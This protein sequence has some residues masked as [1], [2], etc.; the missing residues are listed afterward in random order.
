MTAAYHQSAADNRKYFPWAEKV[1]FGSHLII[2]QHSEEASDSKDMELR[3]AS[4]LQSPHNSN[5]VEILSVIRTLRQH[6]YLLLTRKVSVVMLSLPSR[7]PCCCKLFHRE[8]R[9]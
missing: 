3:R 5:K 6:K 2:T 9:L 7:F 1:R 8:R 4:G